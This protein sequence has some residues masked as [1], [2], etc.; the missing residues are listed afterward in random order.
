MTKINAPVLGLYGENDARVVAS[1][2]PAVAA[3]R[4]LGKSYEPHV[5]P[6]A[7]HSF[8]VFQEVAG[9]PEAVPDGWSRR[10]T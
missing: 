6:K 5:Y 4:S 7:T 1:I 10:R 2:E 8:V 3:M 9:N